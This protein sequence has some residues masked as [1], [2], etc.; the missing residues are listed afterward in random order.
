MNVIQLKKKGVETKALTQKQSLI[1]L[2]TERLI[3]LKYSGLMDEVKS[4]H[5]ISALLHEFGVE[6]RRLENFGVSK[7]EILDELQDVRELVGDSVF[8]SRLQNWSRGYQ[9][10]FETIE[11]LCDGINKTPSNTLEHIIEKFVLASPI[12]QLHKNKIQW[13]AQQVLNALYEEHAVILSIG[14]G[15]CRDLRL[16]QS[17]IKNS[18]A[19]IVINEIDQG[20]IEL[21]EKELGL[22][23]DKITPILGDSFRKTK[24]LAQHAPYNLIVAGG[25]FDYL[26]DRYACALLRKLSAMLAD[27]GKICF[28]N[29]LKPNPWG[30]LVEYLANWTLI[31]RSEDDFQEMSDAHGLHDLQINMIEDSTS[32]VGL[33]EI[34]KT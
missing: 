23:W 33:Y 18:H 1:S 10:D 13:Q 15:G 3:S 20:A 31:E 17:A 21:A 22:V 9:G 28:T 2:L 26:P 7:D 11:Y 27:N 4:F 30:V 12:V 8:L 6:I 25:L 16:I 14:C 34:T 24:E 29:T 32:L 19:Q 5:Q